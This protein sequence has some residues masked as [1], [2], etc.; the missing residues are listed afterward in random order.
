MKN[1]K[2]QI[3]HYLNEN[4]ASK[5]KDII[6]YLQISPQA[7]HR[8]LKKMVLQELLVKKGSSP[9]VFYDLNKDSKSKKAFDLTKSEQAYLEKNYSYLSPTGKFLTGPEGFNSWC[10]STDQ[11]HLFK[12]L[13]NKFITN[14]KDLHE[15]FHDNPIA[16]T[17]KIKNTFTKLNLDFV[18]YSDFWSLP[19]F[20]RSHLGNL[21]TAGKS[22]QQ[23]KSIIEL[24]R[25]CEDDIKYLIQ[26]FD[27]NAVAFA[28]HSIPRKVSFLKE[29]SKRLKISLPIISFHKVVSDGIPIA[30]KSLK[31]LPERILNA[32]ETIF[33]DV[34]NIP[35]KNILLI[36]DAIGSGATLN[37]LALK[38]KIKGASIVIGY[39]IVGSLKGFE[40]LSEI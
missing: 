25:I 9:V 8:H 23:K 28:A 30:Q 11:G 4:G 6:E 26:K 3:I 15:N 39:A 7:V 24:A 21:L 12:R 18:F 10:K 19:Q 37:E 17:S 40:V 14:H 31:K 1:S 33:L 13:L 35:Y 29:F 34:N 32:R 36:D 2:N 27:I 16:A 5:P 38:L 22:G 20:G